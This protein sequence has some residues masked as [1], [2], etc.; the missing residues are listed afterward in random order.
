[1]TVYIVSSYVMN[2]WNTTLDEPVKKVVKVF[3]GYKPPP[4]QFLAVE[5]ALLDIIPH[6]YSGY[7]KQ[8]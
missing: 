2:F 4:H 6:G 3:F 5:M 8:A 1:M 7:V